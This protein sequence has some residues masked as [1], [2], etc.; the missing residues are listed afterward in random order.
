MENIFNYDSDYLPFKEWSE[1]L[2]Y[3][4]NEDIFELEVKPNSNVF[5]IYVKK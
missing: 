4:I 5:N 3:N 2:N 1:W